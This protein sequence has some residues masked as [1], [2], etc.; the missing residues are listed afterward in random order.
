MKFYF[1]TLLAVLYALSIQGCQSDDIDSGIPMNENVVL[2]I[3]SYFPELTY[4]FAAYPLT[5]NGIRL[6][7]KLFYDG[8]LSADNT[9]ACAFC[10]LQE[11]A[12]TH[13]GHA[14]SHGI[15]D[16]IGIRN[17][18]SLNNMGFYTNFSWDGAIH[19]LDEFSIIPIT[20]D[21]EMDETMEN[22]LQKLSADAGYKALFKK[23]Y[24]TDQINGRQ[25]LNALSQ[26]M[27]TMI[28][29]SSPYDHVMQKRQ[30]FT[31]EEE[32]GYALFQKNCAS[33]HQG[34][35]QTDFSFRDNGLTYNPRTE[36]VG[37]M[38]V[39]LDAKDSLKFRVPSLR[40]VELTAPYMHDGRFRT[41]EAVLKHYTEDLRPNPNL[42]PAFK[43]ADGSIGL[44]LNPDEQK[45]I[46]AFLKTLTDNDFISR[47]ALAEPF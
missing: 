13:H 5:N 2:E 10:H 26:F 44:R 30:R 8:R 17:T 35:L 31:V 38:R 20:T 32:K 11:N 15:N 18:P 23:V 42:D 29:A 40:N 28:S 33:C 47:P 36:D 9:I 22:I 41:L 14:L 21:F 43:N 46:I 16:K 4:D 34:A 7:R 1:Y 27:V 25:V 6:G 39:S 12:F 24:N 3:P 37:R 19:Q 45:A